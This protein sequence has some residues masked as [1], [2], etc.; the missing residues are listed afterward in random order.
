[1]SQRPYTLFRNAHFTGALVAECADCHRVCAYWDDD[2]LDD[3][4]RLMHDC[5]EAL[6]VWGTRIA[7]VG[8]GFCR[9]CEHPDP[10]HYDNCPHYRRTLRLSPCDQCGIYFCVQDHTINTDALRDVFAGEE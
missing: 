3:Q 10:H 7:D 6:N 9:E 1:V 8:E 5:P 2:D 4:G